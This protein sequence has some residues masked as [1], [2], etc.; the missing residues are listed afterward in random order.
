M[1]RLN[2][3]QRQVR[4]RRCRR[5]VVEPLESRQLLAGVQEFPVAAN[6]NPFS[7]VA[8]PDGNLWFTELLANR[9][10][11]IN[12]ITH[13]AATFATPTANS[14]PNIIAAGPDGN[15]W[16][17]EPT[18]N[19]IAVINPTTHAITEFPV[20]TAN[21][22]LEGITAG[23]DGQLWFAE[24]AANKI[25]AI[26][27]ATHAITEFAIPTANAG[28][29]AIAAGPDGNL[30]FTEIG[31]NKIGTIDATTHAVTEF[32]IP[33]A[34]AQP[35][36]IAAGPDGGLWFSEFGAGKVGEI[37]PT[38]HAFSETAIVGSQPF[39]VAAGPDGEIWFSDGTN[40]LT[41]DPT[42]RR[43]GFT[44]IPTADAMARGISAGPDGNIWF[45]ETSGQNIGV[46]APALVPSL[47]VQP[48]ASVAANAPFGLTITVDYADS[49]LPDATFEGEVNIALGAN[50]TGATLGGTTTVAAHDGVATFSGLTINQ[51]GGGYRIVVSIDPRTT[52][53]TTPIAVTPSTNGG[54]TVPPTV[55]AEEVV[56]A[57]K[58]R[59]KHAVGYELDFSTA[60]DPAR[61]AS[62]ANY[63]LTQFQRRGRKLVAHP[64]AFQAA[65]DA[66]ANSVRLTL[67]GKPKFARGGKL[68]VIAAPPGGLTDAAGTPLDGGN[69]GVPGDDGTFVIAL[70]GT[71]IS[72]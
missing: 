25:G 48:P 12:P 21:A 52:V 54:G 43:N 51:V 71:G 53:L 32:A 36:G 58:G 63:T 23:P 66:T 13:V 41:I 29:F 10:G 69:Q 3:S 72:R 2:R 56:L 28:A 19:N 47:T 46:F 7:I 22:G 68:V 42:T 9:V 16:F 14:N 65:Y 31:S 67:A 40:L 30:W 5:P 37:N 45:V 35:S 20:P 39:G 34:S 17:T 61:A 70:K 18:A 60:M 50:T 26:D 8:G 64:V 24:I 62:T 27:P 57:G 55:V 6:S 11:A 33:T 4:A 15:V 44:S 49:G 38:T 59:R 1:T